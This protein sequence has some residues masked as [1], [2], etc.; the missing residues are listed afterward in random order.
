[1]GGGKGTALGGGEEGGVCQ[2]P[3]SLY[4]TKVLEM[5]VGAQNLKLKYMVILEVCFGS[6]SWS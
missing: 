1:M 5:N 2:G 4:E 6:V 3:R